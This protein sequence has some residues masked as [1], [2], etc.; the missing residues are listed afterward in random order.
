LRQ[1]FNDLQITLAQF[2]HTGLLQCELG[3]HRRA[4]TGSN[5]GESVRGSALFLS[6]CIFFS[7]T[8]FGI[9][10][11]KNKTRREPPLPTPRR[12]S[13]FESYSRIWVPD[14]PQPKGEGQQNQRIDRSAV[15]FPWDEAHFL[16]GVQSDFLKIT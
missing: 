15:D 6:F 12:V 16:R 7:E 11:S 14:S 9:P 5:T 10:P 1:Q 13:H 3:A 8:L 2:S 4:F